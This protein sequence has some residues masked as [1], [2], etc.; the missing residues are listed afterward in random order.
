MP[1]LADAFVFIYILVFIM[2]YLSSLRRYFKR[3]VFGR[4]ETVSVAGT[5]RTEFNS[6]Y[7]WRER[8]SWI[9]R[10]EKVFEEQILFFLNHALF[11]YI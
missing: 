9:M 8:I 7:I 3:H 6:L 5:T 10:V 1:G 11:G 2:V 4:F